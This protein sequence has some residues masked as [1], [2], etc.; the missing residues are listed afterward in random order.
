MLLVGSFVSESKMVTVNFTK[1]RK[2]FIG[3]AKRKR[4]LFFGKRKR[5][6]LANRN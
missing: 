4:L 5:Q 3:F 1:M 2:R 6:S